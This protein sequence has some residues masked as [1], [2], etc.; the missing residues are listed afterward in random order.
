M[1][2]ETQRLIVRMAGIKVP[3]S[4]G[5]VRQIVEFLKKG[6]H[7]VHMEV[8]L[9]RHGSLGKPL[10]YAALSVI[11]RSSETYMA[12][13]VSKVKRMIV[14]RGRIYKHRHQK[15]EQWPVTVLPIE[16]DAVLSLRRMQ[17]RSLS[18]LAQ[19]TKSELVR[20]GL[21]PRF[22]SIIDENLQDVG[23]R[24]HYSRN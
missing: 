15:P 8:F 21:S 1:E 22:V 24:R 20:G 10:T 13:I 7:S 18:D 4:I 16:V 2:I 12:T 17:I 19:K 6:I 5:R 23:I 3:K 9:L 14:K 11:F